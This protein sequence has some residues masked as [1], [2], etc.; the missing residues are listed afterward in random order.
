MVFLTNYRPNLVGN[1]GEPLFYL[2]AM[3][4]GIGGYVTHIEG[5]RYIEFIAPG[6][7]V[8]SGMY[9]AVFECTFGS[10]TRMAVERTYESALA[11]PLSMADLVIGETLWGMTK[12]MISAGAMLLVMIV[13]G[14]YTPDWG[15]VG[16]LLA[17]AATGYLFSAFSICFSALAPSYEFFNYLFTLFIAPMMFLSGVFFPMDQFPAAVQW[18]SW[19]LPAT[20]AVTLLR[21]YIHHTPD[22]GLLAGWM[23]ILSINLVLSVAAI[24]LV[25]RRIII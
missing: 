15:L 4:Y 23:F 2:F 10:Y 22:G 1:L 8:T 20:H 9:S 7:I 21:H 24:T 18:F 12:A 5:M 17:M 25:R 19:T 14:L 6:L 11:T 13:F 16:A 3:G